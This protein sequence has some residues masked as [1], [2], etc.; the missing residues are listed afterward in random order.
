MKVAHP[1]LYAFLGHLQ[2]VTVNNQADIT[3]LD[4]GLR[5]C[6]PKTNRSLVN[7]SRIKTCI[8]RYDCGAYTP[9]QFLDAMSHNRGA[10]TAALN[11]HLWRDSDDDDD[12]AD[13]DAAQ[14]IDQTPPQDAA[15]TYEPAATAFDD[16]CEVCLI[17]RKDPRIALVPCGHQRFCE[18]CAETIHQRGDRCDVHCAGLTLPWSFVCIK[19]L[20]VTGYVST[21]IFQYACANADNQSFSWLVILYIVSVTAFLTCM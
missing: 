14:T 16:C 2:R 9:M 19:L 21:L 3:R 20:P 7:D 17:S 4:R 12:G 13:E 15:V 10:H 1:N 8:N 18:S 11:E 6:R 5:I